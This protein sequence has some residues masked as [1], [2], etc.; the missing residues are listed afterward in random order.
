MHIKD[1]NV[2]WEVI[3]AWTSRATEEEAIKSG[4]DSEENFTEI[5][6]F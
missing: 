5:E 6:N 3:Q 4:Q 2:L 1:Y